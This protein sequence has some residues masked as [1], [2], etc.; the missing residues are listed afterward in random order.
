MV[1]RLRF[2]L[3]HVIATTVLP[4]DTRLWPTLFDAVERF[5]PLEDDEIEAMIVGARGAAPLYVESMKLSLP[6]H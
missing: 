2:S 1:R 3:T 5:A 4:S 6:A